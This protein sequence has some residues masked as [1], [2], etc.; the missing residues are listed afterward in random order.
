MIKVHD[1]NDKT[2]FR[3]DAD[4]EEIKRHKRDPD[5]YCKIWRQFNTSKK[6]NHWVVWPHSESKGWG[7][8]ITGNL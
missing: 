3:Q 8:R 1:E 6:P 7:E 4:A 2:M 5:G